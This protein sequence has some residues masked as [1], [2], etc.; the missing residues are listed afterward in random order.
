MAVNIECKP[1]F[2]NLGSG[3]PGGSRGLTKGV[4]EANLRR[5]INDLF[6]MGRENHHKI[7]AITSQISK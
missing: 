5:I 3:P 4:A 7:P 2:P 1:G 6:N